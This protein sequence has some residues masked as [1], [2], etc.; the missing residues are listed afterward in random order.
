M[1]NPSLFPFFS[2]CESSDIVVVQI[3]P[4]VRE[5]APT[6]SQGILNRMNEITFNG[7]LLK[8]MRAIDFVTRLLD[9][10]ALKSDRYRRMHVHIIEKQ[11]ALK[12]LGASSKI[13]G[14]WKFLCHLRD[15]GRAT[16]HQWLSE[17]FSELGERSTVDLPAM[18]HGIGIQHQG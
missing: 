11:D 17:N 2:R 16:A 14:E 5:G 13:N 7:S 6:T 3:N 9:E 10:G 1:G 4:V 8:E 15:L 12:P 18:F